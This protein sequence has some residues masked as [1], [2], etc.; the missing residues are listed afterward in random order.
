L[1]RILR[2]RA[3]VQL[4]LFTVLVNRTC[5][6]PDL[7]NIL[8]RVGLFQR[9]VVRVVLD[10]V[11]PLVLR[12][13]RP[14]SRNGHNRQPDHQENADHH[15][16]P[17]RLDAWVRG[18]ESGPGEVTQEKG[19]SHRRTHNRKPQKEQVLGGAEA[20]PHIPLHQLP[21]DEPRRRKEDCLG[22]E[23]D[24]EHEHDV[25]VCLVDRH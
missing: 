7:P 4:C 24:A 5:V 25:A 8:A 11:I 14:G 23:P 22:E 15:G 9:H 3:C 2:D 1:Q 19:W 20:S 18:H 6:L 21:A 16:D 13:E 17:V 12:D 10:S